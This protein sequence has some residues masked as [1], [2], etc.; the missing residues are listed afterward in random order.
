MSKEN[1]SLKDKLQDQPSRNSDK[2]NDNND[3]VALQETQLKC[4]NYE[5]EMKV[6]KKQNTQLTRQIDH[7]KGEHEN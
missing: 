2:N 3:A 7:V 4:D 6:F 5:K 1:S